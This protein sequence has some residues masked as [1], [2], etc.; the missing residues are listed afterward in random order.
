MFFRLTINEEKETI[1]IG[2]LHLKNCPVSF[3]MFVILPYHF[4]DPG[5]LINS[6]STCLARI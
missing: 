4:G 1:E 2:N 5:V 6:V 3:F